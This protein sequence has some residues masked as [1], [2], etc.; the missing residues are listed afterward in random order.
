VQVAASSERFALG[1]RPRA[2][3]T[4]EFAVW[5]PAHERV[6]V[7]VGGGDHPLRP[8][9]DGR[10]AGVAPAVHGDEYRFVFA[11]GTALPDPSSRW[12]P[13]GLRGASAVLDPTVFRWHDS[14][15]RPPALADL[16]L[17]ELHVGTFSGEGTFDG[18]VAGLRRL[19]DLGVTA[20][21]LMPVATF[22]GNRGWGYDGVFMSAPHVAYGGPGGLHRLVDAAHRTGLAV[23]LD[24]VFNHVGPGSEMLRALGPYFTDRHETFWGDALDYDRDAVRE[25]A[26]QCAEHYVRDHHVDGLRLDATHAVFDDR[27]P[28]VLAELATRVHALR[29]GTLVISE[30][31]TGDLRPIEK[32]GHDAQW[33]DELHHALHALLTGEREGYYAAYGTIADVARQLERPEGPRLVV[34]AQNHDQ[35]GNRAVGDRL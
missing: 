22:P 6:A 33:G 9:G 14:A 3:G 8:V 19:R 18:V 32:W 7:R 20:I 15:W 27:D 2:D 31:E 11:D 16:V 21:E 13:H 25:W 5:A 1:A 17:Y 4:T 24:V 12:Q 30:M 10:F 23:V 34:C 35:V 29:P 26:I 28:H